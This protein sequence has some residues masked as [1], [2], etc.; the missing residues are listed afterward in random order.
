MKIETTENVFNI[1]CISF[2]LSVLLAVRTEELVLVLVYAAVHQ[3]GLDR[4][5]LH[6]SHFLE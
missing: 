1:S 2:Q 6:V 3:V 4:D 5:V